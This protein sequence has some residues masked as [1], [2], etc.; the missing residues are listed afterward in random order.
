MSETTTDKNAAAVGGSQLE[1][2]VIPPMPT[3]DELLDALPVTA[4]G[5]PIIPGMVVHCVAGKFADEREVLG[6]YGKEALLTFE[7]AR[8]G[9]GPGQCHRLANTVYAVRENAIEAA[10]AV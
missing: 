1:R 8:H 4:D 3:I 10:K 7:P 6:P 2:R 9:A 5:A